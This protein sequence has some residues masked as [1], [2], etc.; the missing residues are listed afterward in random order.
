T[1]SE[2]GLL[3]DPVLEAIDV[4]IAVTGVR[5]HL[6]HAAAALLDEWQHLGAIHPEH[7][8]AGLAPP[9][10]Q[11]ELDP[12]PQGDERARKVPLHPAIGDRRFLERGPFALERRDVL[13]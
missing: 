1:L 7:V 12:P 8:D 3:C 4:G 9:D 2:V 13:R 10:D 6:E 11:P 5:L